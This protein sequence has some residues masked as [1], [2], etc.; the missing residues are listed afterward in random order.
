MLG[1]SWLMWLTVETLLN[2]EAGRA[3]RG[4]SACVDRRVALEVKMDGEQVQKE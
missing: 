1:A 4:L 3:G 2:E